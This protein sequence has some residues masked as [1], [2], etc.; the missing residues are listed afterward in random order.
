MFYSKISVCDSSRPQW[1]P[2]CSSPSWAVLSAAAPCL[3]LRALC[4]GE[5]TAAPYW[6]NTRAEMRNAAFCLFSSFTHEHSSSH[7]IPLLSSSQRCIPGSW[8]GHCTAGQPQKLS[9]GDAHPPW[10]NWRSLL[11]CAWKTLL[12]FLPA[13]TSH[14]FPW[15]SCGRMSHLLSCK[16]CL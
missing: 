9:N 7:S 8:V 1:G 4:V 12:S 11:L 3:F 5:T 13:V 14:S 2:G 16:H 6:L 15:C 10:L